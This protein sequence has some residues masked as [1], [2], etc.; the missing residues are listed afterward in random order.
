MRWSRL[1]LLPLPLSLLCLLAAAAAADAQSTSALSTPSAPAS[2]T[3]PTATATTAAPAG[4]R[5]HRRG[6]ANRRPRNGNSGHHNNSHANGSNNNNHR[7]GTERRQRHRKG[8][9]GRGRGSKWWGIAKIGEP[10]NLLPLP[11]G[12]AKALDPIIHATLRRRQRRLVLDNQGVLMAVVKGAKQ[13]I[14]ECQYQFRN[15]R[16]NCSTRNFVRGKN[17]FGKIVDRGCRETAFIYAITSAGVTHA[18]AR[19]C[20]EGSVSACSCDHSYA[21]RGHAHAK[22]P[23]PGTAAAAAAGAGGLLSAAP[24]GTGVAATGGRTAAQAAADWEW[25]GCSDNIDYGFKFSRE[26]VDTGERGRSLR[27]KMNLHNNEAGRAH[28]VSEMRRECKCHGM[29]GSCTIRT[30]WMRL[31]SFRVVG[32]NLKDRFD[33]ASRVMLSNAAAPGGGKRSRYNLQLRPYNPDHK[34]PGVKDLVYL[35][36]SPGFC[37]RN[38]RLGIQGTHGRQCNDTSIGVDGCDLMCCGR[39]YRTQEITVVERC[40]CTFHWCCEVKCKLC[41]TVKTIHTCL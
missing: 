15:R 22:H 24:A 12:R 11:P 1:L 16:W 19:A 26:F 20:S 35:E 3:T 39:G 40:A 27:E 8:G 25:G 33:G 9:G 31:P 2:P 13:A 41:R 36:P 32:D 28:V 21:H 38:P 37:E 18:I 34:P 6:G 7:G 4:L 30:C 10:T 5:G 14:L 17:L 23:L 29:S